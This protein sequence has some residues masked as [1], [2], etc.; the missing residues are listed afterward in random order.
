MEHNVELGSETGLKISF[1]E[2]KLALSVNYDGKGV[3]GS[4][5]L[6]ADPVYFL[7]K[8]AE[9]IPGE[10]DDKILAAFKALIQK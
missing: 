10:V 4:L 6:K 2:G 7:E 9:A 8:I 3:D 1:V 5:A